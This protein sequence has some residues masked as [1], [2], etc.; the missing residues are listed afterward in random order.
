WLL[1]KRGSLDEGLNLIEL[2]RISNQS[3][4]EKAEYFHFLGKAKILN[5]TNMLLQQNRLIFENIQDS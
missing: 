3:R 2:G 1:S 5:F 4:L